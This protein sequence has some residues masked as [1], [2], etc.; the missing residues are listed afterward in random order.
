MGAVT[1]PRRSRSAPRLRTLTCQ[2]LAGFLTGT[3]FSKLKL[4]HES[5]PLSLNFLFSLVPLTPLLGAQFPPSRP[6]KYPV[7][8]RYHFPSTQCLSYS[9]TFPPC[10]PYPALIL[11]VFLLLV[12]RDS[13]WVMS[14]LTHLCRKF[15]RDANSTCDLIY[16][17]RMN[18]TKSWQSQYQGHPLALENGN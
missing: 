8:S 9:V 14:F 15:D 18:T 12:V 4:R 6:P 16:V 3:P 17:S 5:A 7:P 2:S 1:G 13:L 10:F 11:L